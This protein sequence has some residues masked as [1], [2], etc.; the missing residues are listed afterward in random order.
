M[1]LE[2]QEVLERLVGFDT[3]SGKSTRPIA[4]FIRSRMERPGVDKGRLIAPFGTA[5]PTGAAYYLCKPTKLPL[6]AAG[7]RVERWL[8][9]TAAAW[10]GD[11]Q[12]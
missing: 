7:R 12:S 9:R 8:T 1:A 3:T 10:R 5:D 11:A 6:T 4:D 2:T